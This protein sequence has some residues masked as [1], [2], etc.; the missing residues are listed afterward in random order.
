LD[1]RTARETPAAGFR[2]END[3]ASGVG[4]K[5]SESRLMK[6][7]KQECNN[8]KKRNSAHQLIKKSPLSP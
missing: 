3:W 6:T 2:D 4:G 7:K 8:C 1:K 5:A